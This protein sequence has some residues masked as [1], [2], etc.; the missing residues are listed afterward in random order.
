MGALGIVAVSSQRAMASE[1][2]ERKARPEEERPREKT[3]DMIRFS[4]G[5]LIISST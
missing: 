3:N 1:D 2:Y 4:S 5:V